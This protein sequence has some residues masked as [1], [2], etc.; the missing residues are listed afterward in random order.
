MKPR[1]LKIICAALIFC[2]VVPADN[3]H[4][5]LI[6]IGIEAVVNYVSDTDGLLEG[7][8]GVND[9]ITGSYTYDTATPDTNPAT[10]AGEYFHYNTPCGVVLNLEGF[11]FTTDF[12]NI[13]FLMGIA[14][15]YPGHPGDG[16]WFNSYNN[17]QLSNG[18]EVENIS[19]QLDDYGG[20]ALSSTALPTTA[21]V[22]S[23]WDYNNLILGGGMGGTPPCY[24]KTFYIEA[25]V[26]S[27]ILI[28]EPTSLF[29]FGLGGL[30]LRKRS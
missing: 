23:D 25:E 20:T 18:A 8:V 17:L 11:V 19:W 15:D 21:P 12:D 30:L 9:I 13:R 16:Y 2:V 5:A 22:L 1:A 7:K 28:P 4:A 10:D 6:T 3:A 29:L 24:E 14:N 26:T 27:T